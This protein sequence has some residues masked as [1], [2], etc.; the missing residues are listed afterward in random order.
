MPATFQGSSFLLTYP[1]SDFPLQSLLD[2][3]ISLNVK[4][5]KVCSESHADGS[6][7]RHALVCFPSKIRVGPRHFDFEARHPNVRP[8]GRK[9]SDWE[10]CGAY[11]AK[12]GEVL[13]YGTPRHGEDSCVW[14]SIARASSRV[15]AEEI[16]RREKPRDSIINA[17]QFD[18]WLD[19]VFPLRADAHVFQPRPL[20][21]FSVPVEIDE[22]LSESFW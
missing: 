3:L 7:H 18:Y 1:Q 15:E 14:S 21:E 13:E 10:N 20:T 17:R 11:V 5:A 8:V 2:H 16:L 22:W 19:K 9:R 6:L 12:D 4:Y